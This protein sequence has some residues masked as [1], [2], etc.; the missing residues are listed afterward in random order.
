MAQIL[1]LGK[2]RFQFKGEWSSATE[3]QFNDVVSYKG[4]TYVY[5]S[6][7]K[8]TNTL[9][10]NAQFWGRMSN[11][12]DFTGVWAVGTT[13]GYGSTVR[14]GGNLYLYTNAVASAG[15]LPTNTTYWTLLI[16][17]WNFQGTWS[18]S[19]AYKIGEAITHGGIAYVAVQD[20]TNQNP[21]NN[22]A[23]WSTFVQGFQPE[24][25][26][27]NSTAYQKNDLV[28]Y[29]GNA[30][31]AKTNTT[32][33]LPTNTTYWNL[34]VSGLN[35]EGN[36]SSG[37][38]YQPGDIVNYGGV[39]YIAVIESTNQN[40]TSNLTYWTT[41]VP[42]FQFE[43]IYSASTTYQKNDIVRYQNNLYICKIA[44]SSNVV[45]TDTDN[46]EM[47][48]VSAGNASPNVYYVAPNGSDSNSGITL[49]EPFASIKY[50]CT[51]AA[52][53]GQTA[54]IRVMTG[55]YT[56]ICPI[57][58]PPN[59]A[60][61]GDNQRTVT[62]QPTE[63]TKT[64]T[65]WLLS[66]GSILNKMTF[67]G[68]TGWVPG[69]TAG[70]ITTS[71]IAG[72]FCRL[73]PSSPITTKS[74]YVLECAAIGSG[75]I[76]ALIDGSVHASGAKSMLSHE[77]TVI[78]DNGI[79]FWVKDG[80]RSE[81]VSCFTYYCYF[82][83]A[84]TG[85]GVIRSLSGNNSYGTWGSVA[86]GFDTSESA[87][88]GALYGQQL[89]FI[90]GSG[91][92][93]P[94]DTVTSSSGATATVTNAQ[95]AANKI[96][97]ANITGTFSSGN[98][99]TFSSGA[100]GSVSSGALE[101]QK[102]FVLV[103][104][105]LTARPLPGQSLTI[106]G[107][108]TSYIIQSVS[109]S[110]TNSSSVV[111]LVLANEKTAGSASGTTATFRSKFSQVRLTGH[112]FLNIGT[113]GITTTNYPGIP[114]Q[115]PV[116]GNEVEETYPGRVFYVSTDQDGNFRVGEY[117][118]IDQATGKA[119]LNA[120]AF[121]LSGLSSL[122]L[123]SIGAQLGEQINEFSSDSTLSGNSNLAVPTE[124]A[125]KTYI[126]TTTVATAGDTMTGLL[127]LSGAPTTNLH[128]AT[129]L[130]VDTADNLKAPLASPAL[131]GTPT[132]PTATAATNTTQIATTAFVRTEVANLV[133]SAP[134][135]L[136][137]LNEL[138]TALGNDA[139]FA[140]T[141]NNNLALK[142]PLASPAL[143]GTPTAPT[144]AAAT[145][146]TQLATTAFV[147]SQTGVAKS[148]TEKQQFT[149]SALNIAAAFNNLAEVINLSASAAT[150]TITLNA[151]TNG[152]TYFTQSATGNFT[153]N[154]RGS[155]SLTLNNALAVGDVITVVFLNTNGGTAYYH[156]GFQIDG[157]AV[158]PRWAGGTAPSSGNA[159]A[160][161]SYTYTIIKTGSSAYTVLA[162][163]A[164][165]V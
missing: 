81:I 6:T 32:G 55:T 46:W 40:P 108:S 149:G 35:Y 36:W 90:Y 72:V 10:S 66:N 102:G 58:V 11:G 155:G 107:D 97:L 127:T 148:F 15:N 146:T 41:L 4:N 158:T 44:S 139:S 118:K 61:V 86:R 123:G 112:D 136:D 59:V 132:A 131:T 20:S 74:P 163:V 113:G 130:Y 117:F 8:T 65:M 49:G 51:V 50:A 125:V 151:A 21:D 152:V 103:L 121:D 135:A 82:G 85:G 42:G 17:G 26:Y 114:T 25:V 77:Y 141:V 52:A 1:D 2:I 144:A 63:A 96:Y 92:I 69:A 60:I 5:I 165:F 91:S 64:G 28:N 115:A 99:L 71:T 18:S 38:A 30:Y 138:A 98:T 83:Y 34:F 68:M 128:A 116:Q 93:S 133:A 159:N 137:T 143:T 12:F 87:I 24:G 22:S 56:E 94:G 16:Y 29:G 124:Y 78:S 154:V 70:D 31:I 105:T 164:K 160:I 48:L 109:G 73:N 39:I 153:I 13:Y 129:K 84:A 47:F 162:A 156:T 54:T 62:V 67:I 157:T 27:N 23:Y 7:A 89:N 140:T 53:A 101:N 111:T 120:S 150:G 76:G 57:T 106:A 110:W 95:I 122:K 19:T 33:N 145:N 45:P 3:Y 14:Y 104:N 142:A 43:S 79:G 119:T 80:G 88:T 126:D 75:A 100:T 9:T 134:A 161:D 147:Q 37:T